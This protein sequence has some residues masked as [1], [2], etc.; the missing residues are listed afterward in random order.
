MQE[1]V[2]PKAGDGAAQPARQGLPSWLDSVVVVVVDGV[3][4]VQPVVLTLL[5]QLGLLAPVSLPSADARG[6]MTVFERTVLLPQR[7][8]QVWHDRPMQVRGAW[9][10]AASCTCARRRPRTG[11]PC[12]AATV[13][14]WN[15]SCNS[16]FHAAVAWKGHALLCRHWPRV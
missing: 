4:S 1:V 6:A 14:L 11:T 15:S 12:A 3:G 8:G 10:A 9:V 16:I 13:C 7:Q 5:E 2:E